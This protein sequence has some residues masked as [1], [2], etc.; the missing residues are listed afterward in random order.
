MELFHRNCLWDFSWRMCHRRWVLEVKAACVLLEGCCLLAAQHWC[1]E[2]STRAVPQ[3]NSRGV[4]QV[5]WVKAVKSGSLG[6]GSKFRWL[7][8]N[9]GCRP[10]SQKW[11]AT[12]SRAKKSHSHPLKLLLFPTESSFT[13]CWAAELQRYTDLG[14]PAL[15]LECQQVQSDPQD[16]ADW[17]LRNGVCMGTYTLRSIPS[18]WGLWLARLGDLREK[19]CLMEA[20]EGWPLPGYKA[21]CK[22]SYILVVAW[23]ITI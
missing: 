3:C 13:G 11:P 17:D 10:I 19:L 4:S 6:F 18:I 2:Q 12:S 22:I 15:F 8:S 9:S 23:M 5:T 16:K 20:F 1:P 14:A 21:Q 7:H